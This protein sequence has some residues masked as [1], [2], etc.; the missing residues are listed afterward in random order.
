MELRLAALAILGAFGGC[1]I[2]AAI[3]AWAWQPRRVS[4]W[5][6]RSASAPSR[7][8]LDRLPMI[9]WWRLRRE[10]KLHGTGFWIRP[11]A[12]ELACGIGLA[13]LYRFEVMQLGLIAP[14]LPA[15][16][17]PIDPASV[18]GVAHAQFASHAI[19]AA[20]MLIAS[21]ID[22]DERLI[23]DQVTVLG[24]LLGLLL[25]SLLPMAFLPQVTERL[26]Q[27]SIGTQIQRPGG[28][29]VIG[30]Q[31]GTLY[32]EPIHAAAPNDWPETLRGRSGP[33]LV[34][35]LAC[36]WLWCFA[37]TRRIWRGRRGPIFALQ[38]ITARLVRDLR[39]QPL[40]AIWLGGTLAVFVVWLIGGGAWIGLLTALI[41]LVVSGGI[42]WIIRIV[43]TAAMRRE[44]MGFGDVTLMM[45]IGTFLGWQAG[46]VIFFLAPLPALVIGLG[47]LLLRRG[48]VI[49]YGP[50]LC[51][52][53]AAVVV[54]WPT[55]WDRTIL[56]F[57][58]PHLLAA[59]L[60]VCFV[61][62]GVMLYVWQIVKRV[63]FGIEFE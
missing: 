43:G 37:L 17:P 4:P 26:A 5:L 53:A 10:A 42:V 20:L 3:D 58:V 61:M 6:R 18:A 32:V 14:Q 47:Q 9:G 59:V 16:L 44:A 38:L 11:L 27:P 2:N 39:S 8:W 46:L 62:L 28:A 45:M 34:V 25:A 30:P 60:L 51:L 7:K 50:F 55:V 35:G 48:D 49:P 31:G 1:L 56:V 15:G 63:L 36:F 21:F 29:P 24:T 12:I 41:G 54:A 13:A 40:F 23:P 57:G 52:A 33:A 19:L 22:I